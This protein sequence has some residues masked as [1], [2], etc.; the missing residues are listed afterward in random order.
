MTNQTGDILKIKPD[1][2]CR[3]C[4]GR[5]EVY[6]GSV[7]YGDATVSL[8]YEFCDCVG[9]QISDK[10]DGLEIEIDRTDA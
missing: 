2:D 3:E 4:Q 8:P 9:D 1:E 5:G 7:P 10:D 6:G